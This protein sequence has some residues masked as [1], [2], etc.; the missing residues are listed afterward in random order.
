[1]AFEKCQPRVTPQFSNFQL[2]QPYSSRF[3]TWLTRKASPVRLLSTSVA[4][5]EPPSPV[6]SLSLDGLQSFLSIL[7]PICS[8]AFLFSISSAWDVLFSLYPP[9]FNSCTIPLKPP[10]IR[11]LIYQPP[12]L[13]RGLP[14]NRSCGA[15]YFSFV[16]L[17]M[18][19]KCLFI[20]GITH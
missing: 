2:H 17:I 4:S 3:L 11:F 15:L 8:R 16:A 9:L 14:M 19:D 18:V 10:H 1:M 20:C 12:L 5:L 7:F 6:W 13:P